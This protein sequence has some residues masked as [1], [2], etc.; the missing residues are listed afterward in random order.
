MRQ[1]TT[2]KVCFDAATAARSSAS[3]PLNGW[4][5]RM[6]ATA[7]PVV[8]NAQEGDPGRTITGNPVERRLTLASASREA[9]SDRHITIASDLYRGSRERCGLP[10]RSRRPSCSDGIQRRRGGGH[11]RE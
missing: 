11:E 7:F 2:A 1:A 4:F 10:D 6:V 5:E 8:E 9:K 3:A